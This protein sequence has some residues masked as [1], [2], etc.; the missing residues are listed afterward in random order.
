[1]LTVVFLLL[2]A[3]T[4]D[5]KEKVCRLDFVTSKTDFC[6]TIPI[7]VDEGQI[8]IDVETGGKVR[9]FNLDTGAA[10]GALFGCNIQG[11]R[12]LG[13][14]ASKDAAGNRD[15]VKVVALP[16]LTF[17][18]GLKI[19]GYVATVY[20][21]GNVKRKYDGVLGFDL[22]N[23]GINAK[24]DT[25]ARV[26]ILSDRHDVFATES[27]HKLKY[28]LKWFAPYVK[29]SPFMRHID[30]A[31]FDT[32]Y[33]HLY[34][35]NYENFRKHSYKSKQ[36]IEQVTDSA[37]GSFAIGNLGAEES[38]MIYFMQLNRLSWG[39]YRFLDVA[40]MT[41][42]GSSKIGAALLDYGS[43]II[44]P[45]RKSITFQP[46]DTADCIAVAN[47]LPSLA[48]VPINDKPTIGIVS[49]QSEAY[50]AGARSGDT[51]LSIDGKPMISFADLLNFP[52]I[53][54]RENIFLLQSRNGQIKE[55]KMKRRE[56]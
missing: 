25:R 56:K 38:A 29:V 49:R 15:T 6:D 39:D 54:G 19:D 3:T 7:I 50:K 23:S 47:T 30:E 20:E 4:L 44:E 34:T 31:L 52:F 11:A 43:I 35:M 53:Y 18:S 1:M 33:R 8:Y 42:Q 21:T 24:I 13:N 37:K 28:R 36:V 45:K 48:F 16:T 27:G 5:A 9:R 55:V 10:Q 12:S 32:G 46:Y 2:T 26:L 17:G 41:T 14:V 22:F 51:I 40:A